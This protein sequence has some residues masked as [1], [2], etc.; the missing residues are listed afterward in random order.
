MGDVETSSV[1]RVEEKHPLIMRVRFADRDTR[2]LVVPDRTFVLGEVDLI[3]Q[4]N[5]EL[6][7]V[8]EVP[9]FV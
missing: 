5:Q 2:R 3:Q 7:F 4:G 1:G 6:R 8:S 9:A